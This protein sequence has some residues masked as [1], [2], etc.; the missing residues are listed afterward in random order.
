MII[1]NLQSGITDVYLGNVTISEVYIGSDKAFPEGT[2]PTPPTPYHTQYFT[3]VAKENGNITFNRQNQNNL[4]YSLDSGATWSEGYRWDVNVNVGDKVM[5]KYDRTSPLTT[6]GI[7]SFSATCK[8]D[9][10]GNIM[11]LYYGD[12]FYGKNTLQNNAFKGLFSGAT[13]LE[14][15][16]NLI[17][18]SATS[19]ACYDHMFYRCSSLTKAPELPATTLSYN[20]YSNMFVDCTSLTAAPELPANTLVDYCYFGMFQGCSNLSSITCLATDISAYD[21]TSYWTS[22]VAANGTFTKAQGMDDW[23]V[24]INGIPSGWVVYP[25]DVYE[26]SYKLTM[27]DGT[28]VE[29]ATATS[30]NRYD[31]IEI[32]SNITKVE[33]GEVLKTID[34]GT[35]SGC[36]NLETVIFSPDVPP[37]IGRDVFGYPTIE[38]LEEIIVPCGSMTEYTD[39]LAYYARYIKCPMPPSYVEKVSVTFASGSPLSYTF[40]CNGDETLRWQNVVP[41]SQTKAN[42]TTAVIGD[43]VKTLPDFLFNGCTK[44]TSVTISD[45]V[46]EILAEAFGGCTNL[47]Q[48]NLPNNLQTLR[49]SFRNCTRLQS[50]EIPS[51]LKEIGISSFIGC[52]GLSSITINEGVEVIGNG[53]FKAS[54]YSTSPSSTSLKNIVI[55]NSVYKIDTWAFMFHS[56]ETITIGNGITTIGTRAFYLD[57]AY[58]SNLRSVTIYATNPPSLGDEAFGNHN[59]FVLYVPSGSVNAYKTDESWK[60]FNIQPIS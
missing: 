57:N 32:Q 22:G 54:D 38:K 51:S 9:V 33:I 58:Q 8:F 47:L 18:P 31:V 43:C 4:L 34:N 1:Y 16:E 42:I 17:L 41:T 49:Y 30:I 46:T 10:E 35:F 56:P 36:T 60:S 11:S 37:T 7:G 21:S 48:V 29:N 25:P 2:P 27:S 13:T 28:V 24:G 19:Q 45:S 12:D 39:K 5:W 50:I 55:P 40:Y 20:C 3:T 59:N 6:Y 44:L 52:T 14:S 15:A 23:S 26:G 53:A